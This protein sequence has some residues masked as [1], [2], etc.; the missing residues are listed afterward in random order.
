MNVVIKNTG[1][2]YT[3]EIELK[4]FDANLNEVTL[5]PNK[6][7]GLA[8]SYCDNDEPNENPKTRDNFFGSVAV[9]SAHWND[10]HINASLFGPLKLTAN[11]SKINDINAEEKTLKVMSDAKSGTINIDYNSPENGSINIILY[12]T[13]GKIVL[14]ETIEK[15][16]AMLKKEISIKNFTSGIYILEL[17]NGQSHLQR[18]IY[19]T[20]Q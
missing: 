19:F 9:D 4:V 3:W 7:S 15:P 10:F 6:V 16:Q 8:L 18:K 2:V 17:Q 11:A 12:D 1:T 5:T 14:N 20:N 13:S